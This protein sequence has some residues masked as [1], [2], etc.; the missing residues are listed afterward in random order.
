MRWQLEGNVRFGDTQEEKDRRQL[1]IETAKAL[2]SGATEFAFIAKNPVM[3]IIDYDSSTLNDLIHLTGSSIHGIWVNEREHGGMRR[4]NPPL[5]FWL[6]RLDWAFW[7]P[8][9]LQY[10]PPNQLELFPP[11]E[12]KP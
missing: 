1:V 11:E 2:Y 8:L 9:I 4:Y 5:Y 7:S 6:E 10:V 12:K 3:G